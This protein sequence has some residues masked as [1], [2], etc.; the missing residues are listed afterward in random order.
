MH[1]YRDICEDE[2]FSEAVPTK[3]V[4]NTDYDDVTIM[5]DRPGLGVEEHPSE[6]EQTQ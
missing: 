6:S 2:P 1:G 5:M 3:R 4:D